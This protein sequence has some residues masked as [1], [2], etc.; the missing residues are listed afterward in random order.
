MPANPLPGA[1]RRTGFRA[2]VTARLRAYFLAGVLITAPIGLTMYLA[3]QFIRFVDTTVT[4]LLPH[5]YNPETYLPFS[6]PGLGVIMVVVGLTLV[7]F[8]TAG[9]V[10]RFF[11]HVSEGILSR[12]PV[13][14]SVYSAIKQIFETV[15]KSQSNAF[16]QVVLVEFP[17]PGAWSVGFISGDTQGEVHETLQAGMANVFIPMTPNI[18]S[19]YLVFVAKERLIPLTMTVEEGLKLVV[20]IGIVSP[21]GR[22]QQELLD[23]ARSN[24]AQ[25]AQ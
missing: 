20:S 5:R 16:K 10:G 23:L 7:G 2:S 13:V 14:R 4:P 9:F 17:C 22:R 1:P 3:W 19:G 24:G 25:A 11:L 18:T 12:M 8:V 15:F 6:I 21:P